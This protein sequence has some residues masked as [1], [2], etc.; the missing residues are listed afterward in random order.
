M[1]TDDE[2][3]AVIGRLIDL[4]LKK[5]LAW[6]ERAKG[7][8]L[9]TKGLEGFVVTVTVGDRYELRVTNSRGE[10]IG[11][12]GSDDGRDS[13][14][15]LRMEGDL[16]VLARAAKAV[17]GTEEAQQLMGAIDQL[18]EADDPAL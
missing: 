11:R 15:R 18:D 4:S 5:K 7:S 12:I 13:G 9:V 1:M 16:W 17:A 10:T 2:T 14:T 6:Y 3:Q 8:Q